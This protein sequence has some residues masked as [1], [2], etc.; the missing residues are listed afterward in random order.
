MDI[1]WEYGNRKN[2]LLVVLELKQQ[3]WLLV[4]VHQV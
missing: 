3:V 2:D 4:V 1:W